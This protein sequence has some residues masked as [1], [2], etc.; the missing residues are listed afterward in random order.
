M[1]EVLLQVKRKK[2]VPTK[3]GS[4]DGAWISIVVLRKCVYEYINKSIVIYIMLCVVHNTHIHVIY[5][6]W[7]LENNSSDAF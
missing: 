6:I 4:H 2:N 3:K 1:R 7:L 5:I